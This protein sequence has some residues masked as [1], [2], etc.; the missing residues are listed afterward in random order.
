MKEVGIY[1]CNY[2]KSEYVV[3]CV[4]SLLKQT[5]GSQDI[6]VV[7]NASED[8]SV[9][10]LESTFGNTI[11]VIK[12][13][14]NLGGSGGFNVGLRDA[15]QKE[16]KYVVLVDNDVWI[17]CDTIEIMYHY[18]ENHSDVGILGAKILQMDKPEIVQDLGGSL[19]SKY[20]ME[21]NYYGKLDDGLPLELECDYI[22]TCTAM[23][24]ISAVK[25]FG[26]MPEENFIYWDDVE[27]SKKCQLEGY[28]TV[29][30]SAAKVWH[31]H[32]IMGRPSSFVKYYLTRN[33]LHFFTKYIPDENVDSFI[34]VILSEILSQLYGYYNKNMM[35]LFHTMV[36]AFEDFL[37]EIRGKA[38]EFKTMK[39]PEKTTPF[40]RV[41]EG[42]KRINIFFTDNFHKEDPLDIY[43][44]FLYIVGNIQKKFPQKRLWVSL[45][46]CGYDRIAFENLLEQAV[47]MYR[48]EF[49]MPEIL[50]SS[51]NA[52]DT[53]DLEFVM[54]EHVKLVDKSALPRVYVDKY[55]NCITSE[56]DYIYFK[57]YSMN[58]KFFKEMYRPLMKQTAM[59]IRNKVADNA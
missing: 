23:A 8:N 11:T 34:E 58:E 46:N 30:I 14:E 10:L 17:N 4:D 18:M 5:F 26:L 22:S 32:S 44:I 7:D 20:N 37:H 49:E 13:S 53:F 33:R 24:R 31:K 29:A 47:K 52:G 35:G 3:R 55:C 43:C 54:C 12:N 45:E 41:L 21:G 51:D 59:R 16:Y 28:R 40:E 39:T 48:P 9:E 42:K 19:N 6:Y 38:E 25:K 57:G 50:F 2:N 56:E 27:W 15:L 1:I 36:Y